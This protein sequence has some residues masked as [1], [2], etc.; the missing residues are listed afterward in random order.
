MQH[1]LH[2]PVPVPGKFC[3]C[4]SRLPHD[5]RPPAPRILEKSYKELYFKADVLH[6]H[7]TTR[8]PFSLCLIPVWRSRVTEEGAEA[9]KGSQ[10]E[11]PSPRAQ[12]G[13]TGQGPLILYFGLLGKP[14]LLSSKGTSFKN[15]TPLPFP[16]KGILLPGSTPGHLSQNT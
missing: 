5:T 13:S 1:P 12:S 11:S 15:E 14:S 7:A 2:P 6:Y 4:T 8:A 16:S 10:E 3:S 9:F